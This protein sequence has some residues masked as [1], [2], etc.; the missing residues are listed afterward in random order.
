MKKILSL[1]LAAIFLLSFCGFAVSAAD[2]EVLGRVALERTF[3]MGVIANSA[4]YRFNA[5]PYTSDDK[6]FKGN[7]RYTWSVSED[8]GL[9]PLNTADYNHE[10]NK[11]FFAFQ[12]PSGTALPAD[13]TVTVKYI[14]DDGI[15]GEALGTFTINEKLVSGVKDPL[16]AAI[17]VAAFRSQSYYT[18]ESWAR[19]LVA[20][21]DA[22]AIYKD[23]SYSAGATIGG[24]ADSKRITDAAA[25]L[26]RAAEI[27]QNGVVGLHINP[28]KEGG[29]F[30][31]VIP[32]IEKLTAFL[33]GIAGIKL[34]G[35]EIPFSK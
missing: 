26:E 33:W 29:F 31:I 11:N 27:T 4:L 7:V 35:L 20:Y 18:E 1:S 6:V 32:I 28:E 16:K 15:S 8:G 21:Y 24:I 2:P 5:T 22:V 14:T 25:T 10:Q 23:N 3:E 12:P 30:G 13:F 9:T 34:G 17:A 19:M